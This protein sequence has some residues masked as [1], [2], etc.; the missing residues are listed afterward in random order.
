[1]KIF[2]I[3]INYISYYIYLYMYT[4]YEVRKYMTKIKYDNCDECLMYAV[5]LLKEFCMF[6]F[7]KEEM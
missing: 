3:S 1:M 2:V 6:F 4:I 7:C 5:Q